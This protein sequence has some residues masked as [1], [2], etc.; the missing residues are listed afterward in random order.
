MYK[1]LYFRMPK[2]KT[3][4]FSIKSTV[5]IDTPD[6]TKWVVSVD[7]DNDFGVCVMEATTDDC[8]FEFIEE[9]VLIISKIQPDVWTVHI[10]A[11]GLETWTLRGEISWNDEGSLVVYETADTTLY[12]PAIKHEFEVDEGNHVIIA[13]DKRWD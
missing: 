9:D 2:S 3:H 11:E 8:K 4:I 7:P 13:R 6:Y 12:I 1:K 5:R 10:E